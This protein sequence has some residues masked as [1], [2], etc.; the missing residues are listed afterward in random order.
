MYHLVMVVLAI[1]LAALLTVGGIS[2]FNNDTAMRVEVTRSLDAH[3]D[4]LLGAVSIYKSANNGFYPS[5]IDRIESYLPGGTVPGLPASMGDFGWTVIKSGSLNGVC[6]SGY[7]AEGLDQDVVDGLEIFAKL[8]AR[9]L[10]DTVLFSDVC[11][12]IGYSTADPDQMSKDN[13]TTD[14]SIAVVIRD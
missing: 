3:A 4:T 13:L 7:N 5:S 10:P 12:Q 1:G 11:N 6:I 2:Y 9:N 8:R 14:T